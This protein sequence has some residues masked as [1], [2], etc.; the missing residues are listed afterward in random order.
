MKQY[1]HLLF[2]T[3]AHSNLKMCLHFVHKVFEQL[4][5]FGSDLSKIFPGF[6]LASGALVSYTSLPSHLSEVSLLSYPVKAEESLEL[7][8]WLTQAIESGFSVKNI[9]KSKAAFTLYE[10][11]G[12]QE[13]FV[14]RKHCLV[15]L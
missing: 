3:E 6:R 7:E 12:A 13:D 2:S 10:F 15:R 8:M 1:A 14:F 5:G 4:P 11:T 9:L